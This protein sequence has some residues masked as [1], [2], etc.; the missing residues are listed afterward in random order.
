MRKPIVAAISVII[1]II[2]IV[3]GLVAYSYT[4][5]HVSLNDV[6]FHSI[7]WASFSWSTLLKLGLN[8]L[9]GN[10][11]GA[12]FDLIDGINLN[13]IF[14]LSNYGVL[15]VYIPDLSYD[16]SINGIPVGSGYSTIDTTIN[17]GET[18][19]I[20]VLQNFQKSSLSPAVVSIID[21]GGIINLHVSGT[22]YFKLL[23]LTI[24]IP[25]ESTK[26]V[27]IVD[28]IKSRLNKEI[29]KNQQKQSK[30][31]LQLSGETIV[32]S[33]YRVEPGTYTSIYFTLQCTATIQ[34]GFSARA[35]LGDDI[36]VYILDENQFNLFD[37]GESASTYY[38]SGKV[39]YDTFDLTLNPG[40]YYIVMSNTY[41]IF[42]TKTVE[43]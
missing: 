34:G 20:S 31:D 10:W 23:G 36:I 25:F 17:P 29:Q 42:S 5:I 28:E 14:G 32:D 9:T 39:G 43:L 30:L 15:P 40:T 26:Q 21:T 18:R 7:D 2:V 27:S 33:V 37:R 1:G 8:L 11:L 24:P 13:L 12:A 41:S 4:Q 35:A 22:A 6:S 19:E 3:L 38:N 16:L